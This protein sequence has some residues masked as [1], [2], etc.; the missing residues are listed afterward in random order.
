MMVKYGYVLLMVHIMI[1]TS[2]Q[3]YPTVLLLCAFT[4]NGEG[5]HRYLKTPKLF[6]EAQKQMPFVGSW[7]TQMLLLAAL[8]LG[9]LQ[10]ILLKVACMYNSHI[11]S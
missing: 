3:A 4:V 8:W 10:D 9:V 6:W 1:Q 11:S 5:L 2:C 7:D